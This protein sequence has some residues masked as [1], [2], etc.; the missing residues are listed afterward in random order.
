MPKLDD[1]RF[2]TSGPL[3]SKGILD[4]LML[5][6]VP[7][8][9]VK[10]DCSIQVP[11]SKKLVMPLTGDTWAYANNSREVRAE[12]LLCVAQGYVVSERMQIMSSVNGRMEVSTTE[13]VDNALAKS[14]MMGEKP[15]DPKDNIGREPGFEI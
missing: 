4:V 6:G 14:L 11:M 13:H 12:R 1:T 2:L 10:G 5:V 9:I 3:V 8:E 15:L 7:T